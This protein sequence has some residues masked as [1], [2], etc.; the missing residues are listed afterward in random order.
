M[1]TQDIQSKKTVWIDNLS[2]NRIHQKKSMLTLI[3]IAFL[4]ISGGESTDKK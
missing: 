4:W 1:I 2:T 3:K